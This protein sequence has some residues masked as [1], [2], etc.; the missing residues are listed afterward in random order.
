[1]VLGEKA[2][3]P[4]VLPTLITHTCCDPGVLDCCGAAIPVAFAPMPPTLILTVDGVGIAA[5]PVPTSA[6]PWGGNTPG[7]IPAAT[8]PVNILIRG[9]RGC[10]ALICGSTASKDEAAHINDRDTMVDLRD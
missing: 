2:S 9:G 10:C 4:L 3:E 5:F 7:V 6:A 1:M 8:G